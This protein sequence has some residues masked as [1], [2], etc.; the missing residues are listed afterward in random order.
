[1]CF[2][3]NSYC[4]FENGLNL[5]FF[6]YEIRYL[7]TVCVNQD[8]LENFFSRLRALGITFTHPGPVATKNRIRLLML[9]KETDVIVKSGS[10]FMDQHEMST[11]ITDNEYLTPEVISLL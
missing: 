1:M 5:S 4:N 2:K 6:R 10:V 7:R 8:F 3:S 11:S 9:G